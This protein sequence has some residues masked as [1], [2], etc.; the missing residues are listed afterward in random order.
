MLDYL[1]GIYY[2]VLFAQIIVFSLAGGI[3][4][5]RAGSEKGKFLNLYLCV[6][7]LNLFA[8]IGNLAI[9]TLL[10]WHRA[11]VITVYFL[12]AVI[13]LLFLYGIIKNTSE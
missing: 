1:W 10:D 11:G 6:I 2:F 7:L 12:D 9:S 4:F 3:L 5:E 8:R 13:F